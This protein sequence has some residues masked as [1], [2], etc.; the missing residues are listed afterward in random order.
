MRKIFNRAVCMLV[1]VAL[2]SSVYVSATEYTVNEALDYQEITDTTGYAHAFGGWSN[3]GTSTAKVSD[4]VL[5]W[6]T[7]NY[8]KNNTYALMTIPLEEEIDIA[9]GPF[10]VS[11]KAK[12]PNVAGR[13]IRGFA[14]LGGNTAATYSA[15]DDTLMGMAQLDDKS[16]YMIEAGH[17]ELWMNKQD[18]DSNGDGKIDDVSNTSEYN[19]IGTTTL[20]RRFFISQADANSDYYTYRW[21]VDPETQTF[22]FFC[23]KEGETG[24]AEPYGDLY[25]MNTNTDEQMDRFVEAGVMPTGKLPEKIKSLK[26]RQYEYIEGN[27]ANS[28]TTYI[29]SIKVQQEKLRLLNH[30]GVLKDNKATLKFNAPIDSTTLDA[31]SVLKDGVALVQGVDYRLTVTN[32]AKNRE[33]CIEATFTETSSAGA[34]IEFNIA[35]DINRNDNFAKPSSKMSANYLVDSNIYVS[36]NGDDKDYGSLKRPFKTIQ[37]AIETYKERK[38]EANSSTIYILDDIAIDETIVLDEACSGIKFSAYDGNAVSISA[39][40]TGGNITIASADDLGGKLPREKIGKIVKWDISGYTG[41]SDDAK[42]R[43][44]S[45][46]SPE[47]IDNGVPK[48]IARWPDKGWAYTGE[49]TADNCIKDDSGSVTGEY[50]GFDFITTAPIENMTLDNAKINGFWS[51]DYRLSK[52]E[53][54]G[55][56]ANDSSLEVKANPIIESEYF[57]HSN[58][59]YYLYNIPEEITSPGEYYIDYNE[60]VLYYYPEDTENYNLMLTGLKDGM[61]EIKAGCDNVTFCGLTLENTRGTAIRGDGCDNL[62]VDSC[63]IRNTGGRGVYITDTYNTEITKSYFG[64]IG[65]TAVEIIGGDNVSLTPSNSSINNCE[66]EYGGRVVGTYCPFVQLGAIAGGEQVAGTYKTAIGI[67]VENNYFH[68]HMHSAIIFEGND[69][70]IRN[71]VFEKVVTE[72]QDAGVIYSRVNPTYRGNKIT[73]NIFRNIRTFK[74]DETHAD[75]FGI[76]LDDLVSD[77]FISENVFKNC[78]AAVNLGG[79]QSHT[80]SGNL[81]YDCFEGAHY[82]VRG[83][84]AEAAAKSGYLNV[85]VQQMKTWVKNAGLDINTWYTRYPNYKN[86]T[87]QIEKYVDAIENGATS[88]SDVSNENYDIL[89]IIDEVYKDNIFIA[90][91]APNGIGGSNAFCTTYQ[92]SGIANQNVNFE[93]NYMSQELSLASVNGTTVSLADE[94]TAEGYKVPDVSN[95]G[96]A[97]QGVYPLNDGRTETEYTVNNSD[98]LFSGY[99]LENFDGYTSGETVENAKAIDLSG[100]GTI[101]ADGILEIPQGESVEIKLPAPVNKSFSFEI[102]HSGTLQLDAKNISITSDFAESTVCIFRFDYENG[103]ITKLIKENGSF[104]KGMVTNITPLDELDTITI[105]AQTPV[106]VD[107]IGVSCFDNFEIQEGFLNIDFE[108]VKNGTPVELYSDKFITYG[109]YGNYSARIK[110]EDDNNKILCLSEF[111]YGDGGRNSNVEIIIPPVKTTNN[112]VNVEF[113]VKASSDSAMW[114]QNCVMPVGF[115]RDMPEKT[116]AVD[117]L[118]EDSTYNILET[119]SNWPITLASEW[120]NNYVKIRLEIDKSNSVVNVYK[121]SNNGSWSKITTVKRNTIPEYIDRLLIKTNVPAGTTGEFCFDDIRVY[122]AARLML[123]T[124]NGTETEVSAGKTVY[125]RPD[126]IPGIGG[127]VLLTAIYADSYLENVVSTEYEPNCEVSITVPDTTDKDYYIKRFIFA[128]VNSIMPVAPARVFR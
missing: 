99:V 110:E 24:W 118:R 20:A 75:V 98:R 72:T 120:K 57:F 85:Y 9:D 115:N 94:I 53:V 103:T 19:N 73:N 7:S 31:V 52:G 2:L 37:K 47:L 67:T 95:A 101:T 106:T 5:N 3:I 69:F 27:K 11:V 96:I 6:T 80:F 58:R 17:T 16:G 92:S 63:S 4:G 55:K 49:V 35:T 21:D 76:Y 45:Y 125:V 8:G 61:F 90:P 108:E 39:G 38:M 100:E 22:R 70:I 109:A 93:H 48:T 43:D 111:S 32:D 88:A 82:N 102:K 42:R 87:E 28:V 107:W 25:M 66:F 40:Y 50:V 123:E 46:Y 41:L 121:G 13:R 29:K 44:Y 84:R 59:R 116:V 1:S 124:A 77:V 56:G 36:S 64:N 105:T 81:V 79:G 83:N 33:F 51:W 65:D 126:Y 54:L 12:L 62:T 71:N 113:K 18:A 78:S 15:T 68:N 86:Y 104:K 30:N 23:Q 74:T 112:I 10:T 89:H 127:G 91:N 97:E 122:T 128:D 26:F 34:E 14:I 114:L 117:I 60:K 119:T